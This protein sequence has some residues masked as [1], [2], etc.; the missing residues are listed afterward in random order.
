MPI[1]C[2]ARYYRWL[3]RKIACKRCAEKMHNLSP[4]T[5]ASTNVSTLAVRRR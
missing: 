2:V 3:D 4:Q 1:D 5:I